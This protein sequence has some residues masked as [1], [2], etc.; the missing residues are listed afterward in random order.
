MTAGLSR[1][2][3]NWFCVFQNKYGS[4]NCI[5]TPLNVRI[6]IDIIINVNIIIV[7]Q[8]VALLLSTCFD[9]VVFRLICYANL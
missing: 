5:Y 8:L 7:N 4:I 6:I 2:L 3:I 1:L 9:L